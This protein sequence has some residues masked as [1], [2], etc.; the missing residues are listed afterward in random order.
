MEE[1]H[2]VRALRPAQPAISI[3]FK[4]DILLPG[5]CAECVHCCMSPLNVLFMLF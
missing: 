5:N 3:Y 4:D 2:V 1:F